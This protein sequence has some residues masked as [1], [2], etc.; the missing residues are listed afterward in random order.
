VFC[1][2]K[3]SATQL[4][5]QEKGILCLARGMVFF[6]R[7]TVGNDCVLEKGEGLVNNEEAAGFGTTRGLPIVL[8]LPAICFPYSPVCYQ[9]PNEML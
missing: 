7:T 1:D 5:Q 3:D 2:S 8:I 9:Q 6:L 4:I